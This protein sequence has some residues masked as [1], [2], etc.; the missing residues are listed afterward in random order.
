MYPALRSF[1]RELSLLASGLLV[2]VWPQWVIDRAA[3]MLA[4][5]KLSVT[6][7]EQ[8]L[9]YL[10]WTLHYV[11]AVIVLWAV[12][13]VVFAML[14]NRYLLTSAYVESQYGIIARRTARVELDAIRTVN[15]KQGIIDRLL[16]TGSL[17]FSSAGTAGVDVVF[18]RIARPRDLER[19]VNARR[20]RNSGI[21]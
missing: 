20:R 17:L 6:V 2:F 19:E 13:A 5:L 21:S 7:I 4:E 16:N 3:V 14:A 1:V 18:A 8:V 9:V 10:S 15:L 12:I 11:G